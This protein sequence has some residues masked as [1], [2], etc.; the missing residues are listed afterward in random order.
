MIARTKPAHPQ[1][2]VTT[3]SAELVPTGD[4]KVINIK[5]IVI[6]DIQLHIAGDAIAV[7]EVVNYLMFRH[8]LNCRHKRLRLRQSIPSDERPPAI[9]GFHLIDVPIPPLVGFR[10]G[11]SRTAV[12]F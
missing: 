8:E 11:T 6:A 5:S 1:S 2:A 9:V 3:Q 4:A 10:T 7:K 12:L